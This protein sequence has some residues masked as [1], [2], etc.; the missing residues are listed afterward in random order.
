VYKG[1]QEVFNPGGYRKF[2]NILGRTLGNDSAI[3]IEYLADL[4][5]YF[6]HKKQLTSDGW[7]FRTQE[8]IEWE[9]G[10]SKYNQRKAVSQLKKFKF[11]DAKNKGN[12]SKKHYK[13]N[14]E[15]LMNILTF[16][17]EYYKFENMVKRGKIKV[18][19]LNNL[20]VSFKIFKNLDIKILKTLY[21]YYTLEINLIY[22]ETFTNDSDKKN[23]QKIT[24]RLSKQAKEISPKKSISSKKS[25]ILSFKKTLQYFPEHLKNNNVFYASWKEWFRYRKNDLK[26]PLNIAATKKQ[27]GMFKESTPEQ[28]IS[29]IDRAILN[30]N[31]GVYPSI[32]KQKSGNGNGGNSNGKQPEPIKIAKLIIDNTEMQSPDVKRLN[33]AVQDTEAYLDKWAE[34]WYKQRKGKEWHECPN[35]SMPNYIPSAEQLYIKYIE[36]M[37]WLNGDAPSEVLFERKHATFLKFQKQ[38]QKRIS[39]VNWETG[40]SL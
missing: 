4:Y 35:W 23:L 27:L 30:S 39:G 9:T 15:F 32:Y 18:S 21:S 10:I 16:Y 11:L 26:K 5:Q 31:I 3:L 2:N 14:G 8:T 38:Y 12:P 17:E 37:T 22:K 7:F 25:N 33:K 34:Y 40:G 13:V 36:S 6:Y 20:T 28:C 24:E 1:I 19:E 29:G